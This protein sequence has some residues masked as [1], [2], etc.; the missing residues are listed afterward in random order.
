MDLLHHLFGLGLTCRLQFFCLGFGF[1]KNEKSETFITL[2]LDV[3]KTRNLLV[4]FF[5]RGF[6]NHC[7]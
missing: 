6:E 5:E 3:V 1:E 7:E 2:Y 4:R